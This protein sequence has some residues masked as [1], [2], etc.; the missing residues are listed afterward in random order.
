MAKAKTANGRTARSPQQQESGQER[1]RQQRTQ[2]QRSQPAPPPAEDNVAR[3]ARGQEAELLRQQQQRDEAE[4]GAAMARQAAEEAAEA[5]AEARAAM[6]GRQSTEV[7]EFVLLSGEF[8]DENG[9][10]YVYSRDQETVVTHTKRL[11]QVFMNKFRYLGGGTSPGRDYRPAFDRAGLE[12]APLA[13][14][15][16]HGQ[17]TQFTRDTDLAAV[18]QLTKTRAGGADAQAQ[19]QTGAQ[20]EDV[21]DEFDGA[22]DADMVVF[23][24]GRQY[25]VYDKDDTGSPINEDELTRK[26]DVA[27]F[28]KD[29]TE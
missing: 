9:V 26:E 6:P 2:E 16:P 11:D 24:Q 1:Q 25:R 22:R 20:G 12:D 14:R 18:E 4:R 10:N 23:K 13:E 21:T 7:H 8:R 29:A 28:I 19:M 5:E 17:A 3:T 15:L 27:A